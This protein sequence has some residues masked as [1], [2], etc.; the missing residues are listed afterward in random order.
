MAH[1]LALKAE[2]DLDEIWWYVATESGSAEVAR[3]QLAAITSRFLLLAHHPRLGRARDYDL[4]A[5]RRSYPVDRYVIIYQISLTL[6]SQI[7][8][9]D[10]HILRVVHGSRDMESI[11]YDE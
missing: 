5:G 1:R 3:R 10:V 6:D 8:D 11:S 7:H 2:A 4:G 9:D